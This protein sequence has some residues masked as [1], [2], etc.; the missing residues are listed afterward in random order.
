MSSLYRFALASAALL[1]TATATFHGSDICSRHDT[2][3]L[4]CSAAA[5]N[6]SD[7]CV[8]SPGGL[9]LQTQL[10]NWNPGLGPDDS[11]TIHGLW[12]DFC[13]GSYTSSCDNARNY[14]NI[15]GILKE[16]Q[17]YSLLE[18]MREY[19][20]NDPVVTTTNGTAEDL[21]EHEWAKH[22]TCMTTLEPTCYMHY[23]PYL[24]LVQF[25]QEVVYLYKT[26]PT[27]EYLASCGI[28]PTNST[29]YALA[30]VEQCFM[31][32]TGGYLPHIGCTGN[33]L[34]EV[35]YYH[36]LAGKVKG[37]EYVPT[38]TT[39]ASNCPS[40]GIMYPPKLSSS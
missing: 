6:T 24:E 32:A 26:L 25:L 17:Q 12:G 31:K 1:S 30:D 39:Y 13:N 35:W 19:W 3:V 38:N 28:V 5:L 29:T 16:Y 36:H 2:N 14:T 27:H 22:G 20:L 4:S 15:A 34:S 11:W 40:Q 18:Y 23:T 8:E 9:L 7:C 37:G 33:Y 10:Y 21:W